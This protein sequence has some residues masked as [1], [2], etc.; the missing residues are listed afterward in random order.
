MKP[1]PTWPHSI[2]CWVD[3]L[4]ACWGSNLS[5]VRLLLFFMWYGLLP[6]F[7]EL[8][9]I[10]IVCLKEIMVLLLV[11]GTAMVKFLAWPSHLMIWK[12]TFCCSYIYLEGNLVANSFARM[13]LLP[14]VWLAWF[15]S[16]D[17]LYLFVFWPRQACHSF[18]FLLFL[19]PFYNIKLTSNLFFLSIFSNI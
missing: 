9:L 7:I 12:M 11:A 3:I 15:L 6:S 2:I 1:Y 18:Y 13:V 19:L 16:I 5:L 8:S 14:Q 17:G 4:S 10:Q